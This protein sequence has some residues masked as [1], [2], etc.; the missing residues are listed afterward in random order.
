MYPDEVIGSS[1]EAELILRSPREVH[2]K[3]RLDAL[4][5]MSQKNKI[6]ILDLPFF[7]LLRLTIPPT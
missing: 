7:Y 3:E 4:R 1:P 5:S 6:K 2:A